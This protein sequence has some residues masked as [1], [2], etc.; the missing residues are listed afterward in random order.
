[1]RNL[2]L[3]FLDGDFDYFIGVLAGLI[4]GA[5]VGLVGL[6]ALAVVILITG[7]WNHYDPLDAN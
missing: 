2:P 7:L 6:V 5:A 4:V 3:K 1:M